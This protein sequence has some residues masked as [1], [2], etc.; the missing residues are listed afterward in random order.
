MATWT[1]RKCTTRFAVGLPYCPH[2]TGTDIERGDEM[3][4]S[5]V[6][7]G[8]SNRDLPDDPGNPAAPADDYDTRTVVELRAL[9]RDRNK[10]RGDDDQLALTG[11]KPDLIARLR[12]D[13]RAQA[14]EPTSQDE[15]EDE[16]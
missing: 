8:Y 1:C 4:K 15:D 5:T 6:L 10:D 9:L 7:G 3:P 2:C 16:E 12:D 11:N 14:E 13:D